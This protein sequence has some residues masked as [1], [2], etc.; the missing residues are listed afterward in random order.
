M[1]QN[2]LS[3]VIPIYHEEDNISRMIKGLRKNVKTSNE[4]IL[5]YDRDTDPTIKIVKKL[6][7]IYS[8]INLVKNK[9]GDGVVNA[10]KTGFKTSKGDLIII[11]M[12]DLSDNPKDIDKMVKKIDEGYDFVC[13]SRYITGGQRKGGP[14]TNGL[15]S[16]VACKTLHLLTNIPT[17]DATNAFKCF[18]KTLIDGITI[19]SRGG[20]EL[21]LE[22]AVKAYAL[23]MKITEIPTAWLGREKGKSKFKTL[24]WI[25]HY[26]KWY[27][28]ALKSN[29]RI[30]QVFLICCIFF[31]LVL[32]MFISVL[33]L[34]N[35]LSKIYTEE[36]NW[37]FIS[38]EQKRKMLFGNLNDFYRF[39]EKNT[40]ENSEM[41]LL[42][43]EGK[44]N[45]LSK[46]YLYPR[47]VIYTKSPSDAEKLIKSKKFNYFVL[48]N[49]NMEELKKFSDYFSSRIKNSSIKKFYWINREWQGETYK[50]NG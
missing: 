1:K 47:I 46:Y 12:A 26:L 24:Q 20:F 6:Q 23:N 18:K 10:L 19:E 2:R 35:N 4:I 14:K 49:D 44:S 13:G 29:R 33:R 30:F 11:T 3:I 31:I 9:Y 40:P 37:I 50:L 17:S 27:F 16:L 8:K 21:P 5:V 45:Y 42:A 41:V 36:R 15:L 32:W 34:G 43:P 25:P 28:F 22:L 7:K 48:Y 38:D 39:L